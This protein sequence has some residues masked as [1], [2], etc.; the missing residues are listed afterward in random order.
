MLPSTISPFLPISLHDWCKK[1]SP[2]TPTNAQ[3]TLKMGSSGI[4]ERVFPGHGYQTGA[5]VFNLAHVVPLERSKP[6]LGFVFWCFRIRVPMKDQMEMNRNIDPGTAWPMKLPI[7]FKT[8]VLETD[9]ESRAVK[10]VFIS[11]DQCYYGFSC[12]Y[13]AF[14]LT[15]HDQLCQLIC[16]WVLRW[17]V[18]QRKNKAKNFFSLVFCTCQFALWL[19]TDKKFASRNVVCSFPLRGAMHAI[20]FCKKLIISE[21]VKKTRSNFQSNGLKEYFHKKT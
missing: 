14:M 12:S 20:F 1:S 8:H 13:L 3:S 21:T 11:T 9:V 6:R 10:S 17:I 4:F 2:R 7:I 18:A 15:V 16:Q 5:W 19:W